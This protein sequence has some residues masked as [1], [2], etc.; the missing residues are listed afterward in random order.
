[1]IANPRSFIQATEIWVPSRDRGRLE[2][3]SGMY[4]ALTEFR[5]ASTGQRFKFGEG[6]P[7]KAWS[8]GHPVVI[9]H[10]DE[11]NFRRAKAAAKAGLTCGIAIPIFAGEFLL[12][13]TVFLCG[14]SAE[15]SGAI[16]VWRTD[17]DNPSRLQ[18]MDGYFGRLDKF[19]QVARRSKFEKGM[20]LPGMVWRD[21]MPVV[22]ERVTAESSFVRAHPA[23]E[24]GIECGI[25]IPIFAGR[26][27]TYVMT[28]LSA[29]RTPIAR[30]YEVWAPD[31]EAD[32]LVFRSGFC[33]DASDLAFEYENQSIARG[34]GI[35]GR[36]ALTGVPALTDFLA[37]DSTV[38]ARLAAADGFENI[39]ALP[40]IQN[41]HLRCVVALYF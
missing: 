4:G 26:N 11:F 29:G 32:G 7:G 33:D 34:H 9:H 22:M 12:A 35:I 36:V 8:V 24:A 6:L 20:G 23:R 27:E 38:A 18:L 1:M 41:A 19:A 25:G 5:A 39:V 10:F 31:Q 15:S 21:G 14:E 13:V 17:A 28:L 30:R 16:E 40:V 37:A 3:S 2:L